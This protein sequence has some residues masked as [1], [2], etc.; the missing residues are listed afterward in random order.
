MYNIDE[1]FT[2]YFREIGGR[3]VSARNPNRE[4]RNIRKILGMTQEDLGTLVKL[5][6]ETISRI[7]GG[8]ITPTFEFVKKF[9]KIAAAA[10]II[11][12]LQALEEVSIIKGKNPAVIP[13]SMLAVYL[14]IPPNDLKLIFEIGIRGYQKSRNKIIKRIK[15]GA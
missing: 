5:R 11:R 4:I 2:K 14:K 12:D 8:A 6:R 15:G 7:E 3:I 10:K 9:S 13:T 1:E